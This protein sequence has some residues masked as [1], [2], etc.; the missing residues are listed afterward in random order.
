MPRPR[1]FYHGTSLKAGLTIQNGGWRTDLSGTNAGAMLGPGIYVTTTLEKALN[2]S[3][4][5][6]AGGVIFKLEVDLGNCKKLRHRDPMLTTWQQHGFDSSWS[7]A[8]VNGARE[9]NCIA[10]PSCIRIVDVILGN[11]G[12]AGRKGWAVIA[13]RLCKGYNGSDLA[14]SQQLP[15]GGVVGAQVTALGIVQ[16]PDGGQVRQIHDERFHISARSSHTF[17]T[18]LLKPGSKVGY[19]VEVLGGSESIIPTRGSAIDLRIK[20]SPSVATTTS[21]ELEPAAQNNDVLLR[22]APDPVHGSRMPHAFERVIASRGSFTVPT[23]DY[24]DSRAG[25][26]MIEAQAGSLVFVLDNSSSWILGTDVRIRVE[27][28]DVVIAGRRGGAR[29]RGARAGC[30]GGGGFACCGSRPVV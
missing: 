16:Q 11:T 30:V 15:P 18:V 22:P 27:V 26:T 19:A 3:K 24:P 1:F 14:P 4:C 28:A 8:G 21:K 7:P 29:R 6:P 25:R 12:E 20:F 23:S 5:K 2:Y 9:E 10:D 17:R 13:G